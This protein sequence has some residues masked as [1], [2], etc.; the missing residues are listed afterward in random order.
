MVSSILDKDHH[1]ILSTVTHS[2]HQ[3]SDI[4]LQVVYLSES[5]EITVGIIYHM[6]IIFILLNTLLGAFT[7][8]KFL[9]Q[10][11]LATDTCLF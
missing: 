7:S 8:T 1:Q 11:R 10:S 4:S 9:W 3:W 2:S 6:Y 5:L